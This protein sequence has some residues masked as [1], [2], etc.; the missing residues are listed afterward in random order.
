MNLSLKKRES[1]FLMK[2]A[3]PVESCYSLVPCRNALFLVQESSFSQTRQAH[4]IGISATNVFQFLS[5]NVTSHYLSELRKEE[6]FQ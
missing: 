6:Y 4:N 5:I 3:L 2:V 1:V